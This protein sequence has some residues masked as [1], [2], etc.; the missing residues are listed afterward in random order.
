MEQRVVV[1]SLA[2]LAIA[3]IV[4]VAL[5][6]PGW[7]CALRQ[8]TGIPCPGCGLSR[9]M[10]ALLRGDWRTALAL[11]AFAPLLAACALLLVAALLLRTE[12]RLRLAGRI[13]SFES[14]TGIAAW[15]AAALLVYWLGRLLYY[16]HTFNPPG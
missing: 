3:Q 9:A 6:L 16:P 1:L 14:R 11:H 2:A 5:H 4:L 12:T 8:A 15:L 7:P 13:A 10:A